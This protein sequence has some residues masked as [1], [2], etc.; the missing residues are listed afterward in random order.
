[1]RYLSTMRFA[2]MI[3]LLPGVA[4][5]GDFTPT[6]VCTLSH[7]E[8]AADVRV[9]YDHSSRLYAI[10]IKSAGGWP[11]ASAFSIRF[12]GPAPNVI[13]TTRHQSDGQT[14]T[15]TDAG[16]GNVLNGLEF[17][18]AATAFTQTAAVRVSLD[19][20]RAPVQAFRACATAPA[21]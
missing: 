19:G 12:D 4:H 21:A 16:F 11:A 6:P 7:S 10:A 18:T 17:N 2:L 14:L 1:M 8:N 5:A 13:S 20:A 9:T 3:C 15:V